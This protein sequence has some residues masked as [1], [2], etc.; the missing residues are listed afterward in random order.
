MKTHT[1]LKQFS[2]FTWRE[3][4]LDAPYTGEPL[5]EAYNPSKVSLGI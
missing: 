3:G 5:F 2:E 4:F 1:L